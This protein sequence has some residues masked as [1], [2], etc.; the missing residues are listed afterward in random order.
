M[1]IAPRHAPRRAAPA[2]AGVRQPAPSPGDQRAATTT[3]AS[4]STLADVARFCAQ[5]ADRHAAQV[6]GDARAR[7]RATPST[8]R[9]GAAQAQ[10]P[11]QVF[12]AHD[13]HA[14]RWRRSTCRGPRSSRPRS[15][16]AGRTP[17]ARRRTCRRPPGGASRARR[18]R[19]RPAGQSAAQDPGDEREL[20]AAELRGDQAGR[21]EDARAHHDAD[22]DRQAVGRAQRPLEARPLVRRR[23]GF[24]PG[25]RSRHR[26]T[27]SWSACGTR[28]P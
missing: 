6:D 26:R 19:A 5:P 27:C 23:R 28:W 25:R 21:A 14:R 24:S 13:G 18:R 15:R 12:A 11:G 16:P 10:Q 1:A 3:T 9:A 17:R 2:P 22:H 8:P 20:G 7:R 4:A